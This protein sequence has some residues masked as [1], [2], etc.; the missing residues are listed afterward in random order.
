MIDS[1]YSHELEVTDWYISQT[2]SDLTLHWIINLSE[3]A[4]LLCKWNLG[5]AGGRIIELF[6]EREDVEILGN[7]V[8]DR[9]KD[10]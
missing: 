9:N 1:I 2:G 5:L 3:I 4:C 10:L 7:F 6:D 8:G